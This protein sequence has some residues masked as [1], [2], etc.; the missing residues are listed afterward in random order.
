VGSWTALDER[1]VF[2]IVK[3]EKIWGAAV[4]AMRAGDRSLW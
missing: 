4:T 2:E 1:R 3:M